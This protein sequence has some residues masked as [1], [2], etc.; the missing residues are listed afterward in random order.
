MEGWF[1]NMVLAVSL[2]NSQHKIQPS[3][4]GGRGGTPPISKDLEA[5]D[6]KLLKDGVIVSLRCSHWQEAHASVNKLSAM[7]LQ[8]VLVKLK[9]KEDKKERGGRRGGRRRKGQ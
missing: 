9:N 6:V 4:Q 8:A 5:I 7:V 1:L 3:A 2:M